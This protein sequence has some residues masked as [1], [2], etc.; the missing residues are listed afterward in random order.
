ML[1]YLDLLAVG[2]RKSEAQEVRPRDVIVLNA[3][4]DGAD[5]IVRG[6]KTHAAYRLMPL[7]Q[8]PNRG[9]AERIVAAA[10]SVEEKRQ[11]SSLIDAVSDSRYIRRG[12]AMKGL[13]IPHF[14]FGRLDHAL[15][16]LGER[17]GIDNLSPHDLR[18]ASITACLLAGMPPELIAKYH[19]HEDL[20]TTFE[21]YVY[22]LSAVQARDLGSFLSREENQ[23]WVAITDAV[24]LLNVTKVAVYKRYSPEN[25]KVKVTDSPDAPGLVLKCSGE[26]RYVRAV[27]L[28]DH[29]RSKVRACPRTSEP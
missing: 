18:R 19:G 4:M 13:L 5:L 3:A 17:I 29:V 14:S 27:D 1:L 12:R 8:H 28:A 24:Q 9:S 22:G 11:W 15:K 7:D 23:V 16:N 26:P 2:A 10:R 6:E 21:H 25:S 20:P